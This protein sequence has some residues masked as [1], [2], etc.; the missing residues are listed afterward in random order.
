[1]HPMF[2]LATKTVAESNGAWDYFKVLAVIRPE[3]AWRPLDKGH[4]P[5]VKI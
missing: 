5:F 4:C 2:L 3:D 1:L